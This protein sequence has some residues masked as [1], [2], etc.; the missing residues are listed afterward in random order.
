M[1][2]TTK[3]EYQFPEKVPF[4]AMQVT[5][6]EFMI[7]SRQDWLDA[8]HVDFTSV[9]DEAHQFAKLDFSLGMVG[10]KLEYAANE[11]RKVI[12]SG[13]RGCGKSVEL[14]RYMTRINQPDAF[15]TIW[16]DLETEMSIE[17]FQPEDLF[18]VLI[19]MLLKQLEDAGIDFDKGEFNRIAE[20]WLSESEVAREMEH[21]FG[22][23][24]EAGVSV[25]WG[26]WKWLQME[27][28]LKGTY[29][30]DNKTTHHIRRL[31]RTN[32]Q[33]LLTR[34]N[35]GLIEVREKVIAAG[36]GRDI[37]FVVDGLEKANREVYNS[38]FIDDPQLIL[39]MAAHQI[40]TVPIETFYDITTQHARDYF[41]TFYLPMIRLNE[42]SRP[43]MRELVLRRVDPQLMEE[44]VLDR[45]IEFSGGCPR[46]L[47]KL[48]HSGFRLAAGGM[49]TMVH[50][51][52]AV[53]YE[54]IERMRT[55]T[56]EHKKVLHA[57]E[58]EF[59][60]PVVRELL[61][62]LN[63]LEYNGDRIDRKINPLIEEFFPQEVE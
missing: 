60:S 45:L 25:G 7:Q 55:I 34:L 21:T 47:L 61:Q 49:V 41:D 37:L 56:L 31:I 58:F 30:A 33:R 5:R 4:R 59:V 9:R 57:R 27:A 2:M 1:M 46:Q 16:V 40:L 23:Q 52:K 24:A 26:F 39:A 32:P 11:F 44:G 6:P 42:V 10:G 3:Y 53:R 50:V 63:V 29:S 8:L 12:F 35:V 28:R 18:V 15:F 54:A 48:V 51:D 13:H 17:R 36:K 62:S 22:V 19:T 43:L 20:D 38:L 14:K